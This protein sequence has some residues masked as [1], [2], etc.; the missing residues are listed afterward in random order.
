MK[1]KRTQRETWRDQ[2]KLT[3]NVI[4]YVGLAS[5]QQGH[6]GSHDY[7]IIMRLGL[8]KSVTRIVTTGLCEGEA[9]KNKCENEKLRT[10]F[11]SR[12]NYHH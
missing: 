5:H 1:K 9:E 12:H 8:Q 3:R 6:A 2:I 4:E 10:L 7:N 11:F